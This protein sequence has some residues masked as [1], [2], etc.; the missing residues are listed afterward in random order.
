M[1]GATAAV[2]DSVRI[3][4]NAVT[5]RFTV[6]VW[7]VTPVPLAV[8]VKP[9]VPAAAPA[10]TASD[11][12]LVVAPAAMLAG[13]KVPVTPVG[14]PLT[15]S[16]TASAKPFE[17][18]MATGTV[19]VPPWVTVRAVL[20]AARA[21]AGVGTV[22]A[23]VADAVETPLPVALMVTVAVPGAA[24]APTVKVAVAPVVPPDRVAGANVAVTPAGRLAAD[25][26]TSPV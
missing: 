17:R 19:A 22:S 24:V 9:E 21:M 13:L 20:P 8:M 23:Y 6:A 18:V 2:V 5:V 7:A 4:A 12:V 15:A 16:V 3:L 14:R 11:N 10:P 26:V 1:P 25:S